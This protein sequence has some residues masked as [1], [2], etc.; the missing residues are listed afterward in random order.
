[1]EPSN[2]QA[3]LCGILLAIIVCLVVCAAVYLIA[4]A[5]RVRRGTIKNAYAYGTGETC[6]LKFITGGKLK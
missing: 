4:E 5:W 2:V 1:M 3:V 6:E